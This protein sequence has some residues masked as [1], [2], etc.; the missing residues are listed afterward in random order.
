MKSTPSDYAVTR[1]RNSLKVAQEELGY[2][3]K[4]V[5]EREQYLMNLLS[6]DQE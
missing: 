1:A 6:G 5:R 3:Y 2:W 4:A